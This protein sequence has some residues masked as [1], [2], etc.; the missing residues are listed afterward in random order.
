MSS[1][2][3]IMRSPGRYDLEQSTLSK[4][5]A[6]LGK[7]YGESFEGYQDLHRWS[8]E[9][10]NQFWMSVWKFTQVV[11]QDTPHAAIEDEKMPGA[12]WFPGVRLNFA[13]NLLKAAKWPDASE[14]VAI[15]SRCE[16]RS[17]SSLTYQALF[18]QVASVQKA[19]KDMGV[20]AGDRVAGI[21]CN[22]HEAIVAMLASASI[23]AIWSSASP[24]FGVNTIY[25]RFSQIAPKV[26]FSVNGYRYGGKAFSRLSEI[27]ELA[28]R[29]PS[30]QNVI[31]INM[32]DEFGL[33][34]DVRVTLWDDIVKVKNPDVTFE[35]FPFNHPVYILYSSGTTGKPKCITHSAGG[36]LLQHAKEHLVHFDIQ[37][38]DCFFF[39][40]TCG[41]MIWNWMVSTLMSGCRIVLFDGN[42]GYPD[43]STLWNLVEEQKVTHFGTSPKF[44]GNCRNLGLEPKSDHSFTNM[45]VMV[46]SG[47]P[48]LPEDFDWVYSSVKNDVW[49]C[50]ISGGT[51]IVSCFVGGVNILPVARGKIQNK[52]LGMD[53]YAF[54]DS[55]CSVVNEPGELVCCKPSPSMPIGFWNDEHNAKYLDAYFSQFEGVWAHG[56]LIEF[57]DDGS[58]KILGRSDSTLNP[59]GVRIGTSEIYRH[60]ESL[61]EVKDS[62]AFGVNVDGD[63]EIMLLV[64]LNEG[65]GLTDALIS[66][67]KQSL[68]ANAS[69]RHVPR[70]MY[71]V[72]DIP[73]TRTGKKMEVAAAKMFRGQKL[74]NLGAMA[75]P[76]A[77]DELRRIEKSFITK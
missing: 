41:W 25:D 23:G 33:P 42:P 13:E 50:S 73:Y 77:M 37:Q 60:V 5:M 6:F 12:E 72:A 74:D 51:D 62:L 49:L 43:I 35:A 34:N 29:I 4:Y 70:F 30:I 59:G 18:A 48:L 36:A 38:D 45:R 56:D 69:P 3:N 47:S 20:N 76:D 1:E 67:I 32:N 17:E 57:S 61:N 46:T 21:V 44:L 2:K 16:G 15:L 14:R 9:N 55:G 65:F 54:D 39:F 75:N 58:C 24:D 71:E 64:V 53:V 7:E 68:R 28:S 19:L 31:L 27:Q 66:K 11:S 10:L 22:T 8:V 40:T 52:L 26:L 63:S